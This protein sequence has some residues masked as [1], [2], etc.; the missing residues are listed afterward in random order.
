VIELSLRFKCDVCGDE[1]TKKEVLKD[2][3]DQDYFIPN[4]GWSVSTGEYGF[5]DQVRCQSCIIE[6]VKSVNKEGAQLEIKL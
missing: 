6:S 5:I 2:F 4:N 3:P 1:Q